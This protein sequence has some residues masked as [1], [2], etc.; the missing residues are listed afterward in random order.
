M[1][2]EDEWQNSLERKLEVGPGGVDRRNNVVTS[3][4]RPTSQLTQSRS[5]DGPDMLRG[6]KSDLAGRSFS[7]I[8]L[9][10]YGR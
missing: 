6:L 1:K 4:A 9:A 7:G 2:L 8:Y 10:F 5:S 3:N